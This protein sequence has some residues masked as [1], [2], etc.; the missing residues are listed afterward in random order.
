MAAP[1][2]PENFGNYAIQGIAEVLPPE[3]VSWFPVTAGWQG[4]AVLGL[5][6]A[7]WFAFRLLRR[8]QRNR[9]RRE[10]LRTLDGLRNLAPAQRLDAI[11]VVLKTTALE[12]WPR[13]EVAAL[14][15]TPWL[16]WLEDNGAGLSSASRQLLGA[17]QY[18]PATSTDADAMNT[19]QREVA[20]WIRLHRGAAP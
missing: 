13:P 12:A 7:G 16:D 17:G 6:L 10:A 19:L 8:R 2:L 5:G 18:R 3:P 11:A 4:L 15:G 1:P 14:S 9:Y 20:A